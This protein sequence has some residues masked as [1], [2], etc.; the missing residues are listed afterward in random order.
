MQG[1]IYD[2]PALKKNA[3]GSARGRKLKEPAGHLTISYHRSELSPDD[4]TRDQPGCRAHRSQ[5]SSRPRGGQPSERRQRPSR[6]T[7][8]ERQP[9]VGVERTIEER[10]HRHP[11]PRRA[12]HHQEHAGTAQSRR[13]RE[14]R[15]LP[16]LAPQRRPGQREHTEP[17]RGQWNDL[18]QRQRTETKPRRVACEERRQLSRAQRIRQ[19][20][21]H[22]LQ[23]VQQLFT[24]AEAKRARRPTTR[25]C[26]RYAPVVTPAPVTPQPIERKPTLVDRIVASATI[27]VAEQRQQQEREDASD[28]CACYGR[29]SEPDAGRCV[30]PT[31]MVY[32]ASGGRVS[33]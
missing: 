31:R 14:P 22:P 32:P 17:E 10:S 3:G 21:Q 29:R 33:F 9:T 1:V 15:K 18:I 7:R 16:P 11:E 12:P 4:F 13:T 19:I 28:Q 30:R 8:P 20:A 27:R 6:E 23:F 25:A 26:P 5:P 2:A 24:R